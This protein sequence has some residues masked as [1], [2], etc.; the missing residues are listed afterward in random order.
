MIANTDIEVVICAEDY[1]D[2][3]GIN[4]LLERG[5]YIE[6]AGKEWDAENPS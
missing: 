6:I 2:K 4:V 1:V 5:C 3:R